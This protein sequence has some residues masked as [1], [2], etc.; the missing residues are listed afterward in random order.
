MAPAEQNYTVGDQ[1]MLVIVMSCRHWWH[2]LGGARHPK[3]V[4]TDHQNLQRFM[5]TKA[6]TGR[7]ARWWE[8]L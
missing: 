1:E 8:T 7:Q 2:Y 6:L 4:L 5:T 3:E